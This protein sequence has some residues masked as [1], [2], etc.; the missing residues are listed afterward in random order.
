MNIIF[1]CLGNVCRSVMAEMIMKDLLNRAG[2]RDVNVASCGI[3]NEEEG[4]PIYYLAKHKLEEKGISVFPHRARQM[5]YNDYLN[6]DLI[7]C[8]DQS[9]KRAVLNLI[10]HDQDAKVC[11]LKSF[12]GKCDDV[13]DPWYTRDFE[14]TFAEIKEACEVLLEKLR[15]DIYD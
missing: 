8:M 13:L 11:M 4:A 10:G 3:S 14:T 6:N 12:V 2:I 9:N 7:I 15:R 1:V 5:S